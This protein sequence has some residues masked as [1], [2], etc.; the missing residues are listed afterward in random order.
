MEDVLRQVK[1]NAFIEERE[2]EKMG[3]VVNESEGA[4]SG[5][6]RSQDIRTYHEP[7][8]RS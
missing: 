3:R 1:Q 6:M 8:T 4:E 5:G 2:R 7:E